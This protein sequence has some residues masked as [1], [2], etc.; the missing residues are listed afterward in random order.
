MD[1]LVVGGNTLLQVVGKVAERR[2]PSLFNIRGQIFK[3]VHLLAATNAPRGF[4]TSI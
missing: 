2:S 1:G 3:L 4:K